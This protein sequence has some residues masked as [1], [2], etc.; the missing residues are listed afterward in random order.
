MSTAKISTQRFIKSRLLATFLLITLFCFQETS[1]A[2]TPV[3]YDTRPDVKAL[4][5][6]IQSNPTEQ[7]LA[8]Y[9]NWTVHAMLT[10]ADW[11]LRIRGEE[12]TADEIWADWNE[13]SGGRSFTKNNMMGF[14]IGDHAPLSAELSALHRKLKAKLGPWAMS[15]LQLDDLN[16]LNFALPVVMHPQR[17]DIDKEEYTRHFIPLSR[18]VA[19]WVGLTACEAALPFPLISQICSSAAA[20]GASFM[21]QNFSV[22]LSNAVWNARHR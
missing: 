2:A 6:N 8:W 3:T 11:Y 14:D 9:L 13:I 5:E 21:A 16:T 22:Y 10:R 19:F 15:E 7:K 1:W 4:A 20:I 12:K 18:I 17:E